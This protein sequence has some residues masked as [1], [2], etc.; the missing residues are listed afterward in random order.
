M[1]STDD[2]IKALKLAEEYH[3]DPLRAACIDK[4]EQLSKGIELLLRRLDLCIIEREGFI[5]RE[6]ELE[7]QAL[8]EFPYGV[9]LRGLKFTDGEWWASVWEIGADSG[10]LCRGLTPRAAIQAALDKMKETK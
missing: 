7:A 6:K 9:E 1:N 3:H 5:K 10:W 2:I 8:L 4:L